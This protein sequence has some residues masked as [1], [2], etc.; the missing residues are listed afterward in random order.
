MITSLIIENWKSYQ[1]ATLQVDPLTVII[2]TNA[3]GKSNALDAL[4]M[5]NRISMGALLASALQGDTTLSP[6]RGGVEWAARKPGSVFELG[7]TCGADDATGYEYRIQCEVNDGR[8]EVRSE[9]LTRTKYRPGRGGRRTVVGAI[10]LFRTDPCASDSPTIVARLYN[11]KQGSPRTM[12]RSQA[13]IYQLMG[14]KLRQE[15]QE[16]LETVLKSLREIF[17]LDPIPSHMRGYS[18]LSEGLESDASNI[19]GIIAA[20]GDEKQAEI[21]DVLT[22]Y[23]SKLPER[24]INR[25]YAERVGKFQSDAMLYCEEAW[26]K[27]EGISTVDARGMSDGT[28]RFLAILTALLTRPTGSLL[29]VEEVDNGLHPSRASMLLDML[30]TVGR[31]RGVDVVATT[32]NPALLDAMGAEMLPFITVAHRDPKSGASALTLLE[33]VQQ[34]PKLLAQGSIGRLSSKGLIEGAL[35]R[36]FDFVMPES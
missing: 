35:Q 27:G 19:A 10:K 23:A 6:I 8:C 20:L 18:P 5:L 11:E 21:E 17:I 3:S 2:G 9:Q 28:L 34:L 1:G 16:G 13:I 25:V 30:C 14:Q 26:G 33:D 24:D 4:A 12:G 7:V 15:I 29:V 22:S 31:S 36:S 32:H